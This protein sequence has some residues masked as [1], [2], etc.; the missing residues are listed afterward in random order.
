[1]FR[2]RVLA[3][4][5]A[6]VG[7]LSLGACIDTA[8]PAPVDVQVIEETEFAASLEIDLASMTQTAS[9]LYI[10]TIAEG[11]GEPAVAGNSVTVLY[12]GALSDGTVFDSSDQGGPFDFV[13]GIG[14]VV[15]GFDEGVIGMR[16]GGVRKI[17]IPPILGYGTQQVGVIPGGSIL[18]FRIELQSIVN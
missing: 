11:T 5:S 16:V 9:G 3:L 13:L 4:T 1:M 7:L 10:R 14:G 6:V 18:I 12:A 17:I 8:G 2:P 15:E